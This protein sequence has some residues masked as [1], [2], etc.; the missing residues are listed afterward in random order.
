MGH[1][2]IER[3]RQ[4]HV[5]GM[6]DGERPVRFERDHENLIIATHYANGFVSRYRY[7]ALG[8][9]IGVEHS[10]GSSIGYRHDSVGNIVEIT[11]TNADGEIKR[12][13]IGIGEM[14]QV[15]QVV[16]GDEASAMRISY[17]GLGRPSRIQLA[18]DTIDIAYREGGTG[19]E[20]RSLETGAIWRGDVPTHHAQRSEARSR[21]FQGEVAARSQAGHATI[22]F[23]ELTYAAEHVDPLAQAVPGWNDAQAAMNMGSSLLRDDDFAAT[24]EFEKPSNA[25]FHPSEYRSM[26]CCIPCHVNHCNDCTVG[27][28]FASWSLCFCESET[29]Y[30]GFGNIGSGQKPPERDQLDDLIEEYEDHDADDVPKRGD[31]VKEESSENF[32]YKAYKADAYDY[33]IMG[34]MSEMAEAIRREYNRLIDSDPNTDYGLLLTSGYR[35]PKFNSELGGNKNSK[36]MYGEAIDLVPFTWPEQRMDKKAA[37]DILTE[38]V[39]EIYMDNKDYDVV[40]YRVKMYIHIEYDPK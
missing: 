1:I 30:Y 35:N 37:F 38:A 20:L 40:V 4:G 31:F 9:R 21:F 33:F 12:Q 28:N 8:N 17:D 14:N 6:H 13:Q 18:S 16:Y 32:S 19:M 26:N 2:D 15:D 27:G 39:N 23:D 10:L 24:T 11:V 25:L 22:R 5:T 7:D 36:H 29:L 34:M 3:D